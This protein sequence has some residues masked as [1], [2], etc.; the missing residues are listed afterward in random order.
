MIWSSMWCATRRSIPKTGFW[1]YLKKDWFDCGFATEKGEGFDCGLRL[2]EEPLDCFDCR[3]RLGKELLL[4]LRL[5]TAAPK[6]GS[7][8][9]VASS[10]APL[11][12][13]TR[14][15]TATAR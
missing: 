12:L 1:M 4:L 11:D 13:H 14:P 2:G 3:L 7:A 15:S 5:G 9:L 8:Y 10:Q 6:G